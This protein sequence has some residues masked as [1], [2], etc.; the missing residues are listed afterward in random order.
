MTP[1][2]PHHWKRTHGRV[3]TQCE[4]RQCQQRPVPALLYRACCHRPRPP[5][6]PQFHLNLHRAP[7]LWPRPDSAHERPS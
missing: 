6:H 3:D 7:Q 4:T 2:M 5:T 1:T